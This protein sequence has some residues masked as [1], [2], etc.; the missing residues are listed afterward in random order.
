MTTTLER[1]T[2]ETRIRV[3][4]GPGVKPTDIRTPNAFLSHMVETWSKYSGLGVKLRAESRD[5]V[6]HHLVEDVAITLGRAL[7]KWLGDARIARYGKA[8]VP[9]DDALVA[10]ALDAGGRAYYEGPLPMAMYEH[11]LRSLAFEAG[12]TLHVSVERGREEHHIVEAAVKGFGMALRDALQA[13]RDIASTKGQVEYR[14][15]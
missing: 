13:S 3:E 15:G 10:V 9:M 5:D 4:L 12:F 14:G 1:T 2:K 11:F 8:Y 6:D 7:R